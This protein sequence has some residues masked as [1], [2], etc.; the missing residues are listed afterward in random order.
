MTRPARQRQ[1][2]QDSVTWFSLYY[3]WLVPAVR[4]TPCGLSLQRDPADG[5]HA[6][7]GLVVPRLMD[8]RWLI[9]RHALPCAWCLQPAVHGYSGWLRQHC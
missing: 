6:Y 3:R 1:W 5:N 8:A 7:G 4:P 2:D 9:R